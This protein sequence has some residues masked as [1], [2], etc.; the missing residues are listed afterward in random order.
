MKQ[1]GRRS[2]EALVI[3]ASS[4]LEITGRVKP[5]HDLTDEATEVWV[6]IVNSHPADH[7]HPGNSPLL[8]QYCRHVIEA[9]RVGELIERATADKDLKAASLA[10]LYR[11]QQAES[12]VMTTLATKLRLTNQS[13][14]NHRGNRVRGP[15]GK[16]WD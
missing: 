5:P 4:P 7:F 3:A 9:R 15:A 1:R 16:P 10:R 13:T 14:V 8:T 11:M 12:L 2:A 6:A